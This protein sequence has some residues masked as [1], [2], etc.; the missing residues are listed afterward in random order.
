[1]SNHVIRLKKISQGNGLQAMLYF[2][3]SGGW[4]DLNKA[5]L[6]NLAKLSYKPKLNKKDKHV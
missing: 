3:R 1:M 6:I 5:S 2:F 4:D